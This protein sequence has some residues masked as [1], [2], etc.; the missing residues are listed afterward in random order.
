MAQ[1]KEERITDG[2]YLED[3]PRNQPTSNFSRP[4]VVP[5]YDPQ[6]TNCERPSTISSSSCGVASD[7]APAVRSRV[8][9][10]SVN[11]VGPYGGNQ[12]K[13]QARLGIRHKPRSFISFTPSELPGGSSSRALS[14]NQIYELNRATRHDNGGEIPT[15]LLEERED[16]GS[17]PPDGGLLAWAH[18][19][20]GFLVTLNT[21]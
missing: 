6:G 20:A 10:E 3:M 16:S 5:V 1:S 7:G 11:N 17:E 18:A 2:V 13:A 9:E 19:I 15:P 4:F 12:A 14:H 8:V 21:Q